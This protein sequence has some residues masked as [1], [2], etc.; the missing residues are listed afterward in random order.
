[1][2]G[3]NQGVGC[4]NAFIREF[5]QRII[6]TGWQAWDEHV[7]TSDRFSLH[8]Q[9]KTVVGVEHYMMLNVNRYITYE[10]TRFRFGVSDIKEHRSRF[11]VYNVDELKCPLCLSA[12]DNEVHFVLCC[13]A[14]LCLCLC[15][16][17]SVCLSVCLS[18]SLSVSL[19]L[20]LSLGLGK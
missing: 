20:S 18:L 17:L 6:D 3:Y 5:R 15:L 4:L 13:P 9:F 1:M 7:N 11:K 12:A 14:S 19:S 10:L 8:G 16:S 2:F